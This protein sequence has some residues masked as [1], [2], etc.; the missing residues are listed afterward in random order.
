MLCMINK[1]HS[2]RICMLQSSKSAQV[3][4]L[5]PSAWAQSVTSSF[6]QHRGL[7]CPCG[8]W[9]CSDRNVS[10]DGPLQMALD[11]WWHEWDLKMKANWISGCFLATSCL[12]PTS[13]ITPHITFFCCYPSRC[14]PRLVVCSTRP[15][16]AAEDPADTIR[17]ITTEHPDKGHLTWV[18]WGIRWRFPPL[19]GNFSKKIPTRNPGPKCS[20]NVRYE[21]VG[22]KKFSNFRIGQSHP[23]LR[24]STWSKWP[25]Q[26]TTLLH[27]PLKK[28]LNA[29]SFWKK[30]S[31]LVISY[32]SFP[33]FFAV[34]WRRVFEL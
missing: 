4:G 3:L 19:Q 9:C 23:E 24:F 11:R 20:H 26:G 34:S 32:V 18:W 7:L 16:R 28:I 21:Q 6:P 8:L 12:L 22:K 17:Q 30:K 5:V 13:Q 29:D 14:G 10:F 31:F 33:W 1:H 15:T 27:F 2:H 25:P